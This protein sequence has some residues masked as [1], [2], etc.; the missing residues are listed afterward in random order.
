M[1]GVTNFQKKPGGGR[2]GSEQAGSSE[3]AEK[4]VPVGR[5]LMRGRWVRRNTGPRA[6]PLLSLDLEGVGHGAEGTRLLTRPPPGEGGGG[7]HLRR[8]RG[9]PWKRGVPGSFFSETSLK[10]PPLAGGAMTLKRSLEGARHRRPPVL[11]G[12]R[13][14]HGLW[15][16]AKMGWGDVWR[17]CQW[18]VTE[19]AQERETVNRKFTENSGVTENSPKP[20]FLMRRTDGAI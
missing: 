6:G 2:V 14:P 15:A 11:H 7:T 5:C 12:R 4:R 13:T 16:A 1:V 18:D 19:M 17:C 3:Q 9:S 10:F 8:V 20:D